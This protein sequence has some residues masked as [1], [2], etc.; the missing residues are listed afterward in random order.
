MG[1]VCPEIFRELIL[2]FSVAFLFAFTGELA[3]IPCSNVTFFWFSLGVVM[4]LTLTVTVLNMT[5]TVEAKD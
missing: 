1:N 5:I 2:V 4:L 3:L